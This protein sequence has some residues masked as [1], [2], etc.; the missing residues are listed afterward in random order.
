[1][2]RRLQARHHNR[3]SCQVDRESNIAVTRHI[4]GDLWPSIERRPQHPHCDF[5]GRFLRNQINH[6]DALC[7]H[8]P[9]NGCALAPQKALGQ[10]SDSCMPPLK[11]DI[12]VHRHWCP[13]IRLSSSCIS[14][15]EEAEPPHAFNERN[16]TGL[17]R[18]DNNSR[19]HDDG[20]PVP[21]VQLVGH[22][23]V[24]VDERALEVLD[25]DE[26]RLRGTPCHVSAASEDSRCGDGGA[27]PWDKTCGAAAL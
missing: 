20:A 3:S 7:V 8:R 1:M 27:A 11:I 13:K 6:C 12:A 25:V 14:Q 10:C 26:R 19:R 17:L 24:S 2:L 16:L 4:V 5:C 22:A 15:Q 21:S 18:I 23:V 9:V